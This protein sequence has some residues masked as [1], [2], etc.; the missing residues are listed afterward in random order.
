MAKSLAD[1]PSVQLLPAML[2]GLALSTLAVPLRVLVGL[3]CYYAAAGASTDVKARSRSVRARRGSAASKRVDDVD[4]GGAESLI[5][6]KLS[7]QQATQMLYRDA[8]ENLVRCGRRGHLGWLAWAD[9]CWPFFC[10]ASRGHAGVGAECMMRRAEHGGTD[11]QGAE[12]PSLPL[13]TP[14]LPTK[15]QILVAT[16]AACTTAVGLGAERLL[17]WPPSPWSQLMAGGL[18]F[19]TL[20][21][22][23]KVC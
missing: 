19:S 10:R 6:A 11:M 16:F 14:L 13:L 17:G 8:L 18:I 7:I 23:A 1:A 9:V 21:M 2:L 22:L 12:P 20:A 5:V 15:P 3:R 4:L